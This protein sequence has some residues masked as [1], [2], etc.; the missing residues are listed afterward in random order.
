M[1]ARP[2]A[3]RVHAQWR[4]RRACTDCLRY[5]T[6]IYMV[7]PEVELHQHMIKCMAVVGHVKSEYRCVSSMSWSMPCCPVLQ[8]VRFKV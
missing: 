8:D 6:Y 5:L 2:P 4:L 3:V 7:L 1:R